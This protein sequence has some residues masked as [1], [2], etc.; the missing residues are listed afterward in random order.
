MDIVI[1]IKLWSML[2][3]PLSPMI[4]LKCVMTRGILMTDSC[5]YKST[6][7][8]TLPSTSLPLHDLKNSDDASKQT[9]GSDQPI[10]TD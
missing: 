9:H 6:W 2:L 8:A 7:F 1:E 3:M 10:S 5:L 4:G